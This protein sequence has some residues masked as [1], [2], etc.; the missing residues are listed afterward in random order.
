MRISARNTLTGTIT[1]IKLGSVNAEVTIE[2]APKVEMV[3]MIS[4]ES[5][6]TLKLEPGIRCYAV[7]KASN[8]MVGVDG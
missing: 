1:G 2:I 6:K 8:V 3:A 4:V 7:I 5:V